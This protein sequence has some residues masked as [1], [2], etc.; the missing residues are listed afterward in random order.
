MGQTIMLCFL[1][2]FVVVLAHNMPGY[3][4]DDMAI[5][6]HLKKIEKIDYQMECMRE[7][8][9]RQIKDIEEL[10][11]AKNINLD[12]EPLVIDPMDFDPRESGDLIE[13]VEDFDYTLKIPSL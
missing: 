8:E 11:A 7:I 3:S 6:P 10:K 1:P 4:V 13:K 9:A 12:I 2:A 5:R